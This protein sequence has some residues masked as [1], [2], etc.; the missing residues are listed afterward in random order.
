MNKNLL[1]LCGNA[2]SIIEMGALINHTALRC[3]DAVY[4]QKL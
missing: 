1:I 4:H 2:C 3:R